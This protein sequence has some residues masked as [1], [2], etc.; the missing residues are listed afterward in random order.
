[1]KALIKEI[2]RAF[3]NLLIGFIALQVFIQLLIVF[4]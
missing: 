3:I 2:G 1:M 4:L